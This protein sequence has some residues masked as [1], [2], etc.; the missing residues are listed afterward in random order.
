MVSI[1]ILA[2]ASS[3]A[4]CGAI[5]GSKAYGLTRL[6]GAR[7]LPAS[8][9]A[10]TSAQRPPTLP[11][12]TGFIPATDFPLEAKACS[13]AQATSVLPTPVSVPV[14][15]KPKGTVVGV[16]LGAA[17]ARLA[18]RRGKPR[19]VL[20]AVRRGKGDSQ[21]RR[22]LGHRGRTDRRHQDA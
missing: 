2:P 15:K 22:A 7:M 4:M 10:S 19:Q 13:S 1:S 18:K 17:A 20:G 9:R 11:A 6:A 21:S 14:T 3:A 5:A 8:T 16:R 12:A